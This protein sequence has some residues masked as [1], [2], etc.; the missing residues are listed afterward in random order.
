MQVGANS[1]LD[2]C[3]LENF[4]FVGMGASV[5]RGAKVESF[6]VLSAGGVLEEGN[7]VPS[8][9]IFAGS[10]AAYLRDL[11]QEEKHLMAEHKLEMQ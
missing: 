1:R 6:G 5:H 11:T 2:A 3:T 8:G 4:A 9:Q 7:T 10:P